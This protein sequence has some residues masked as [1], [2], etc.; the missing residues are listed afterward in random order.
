M[1]SRQHFPIMIVGA[2]PGDPDLL[3][4]KAMRL[5]GE[6]DVIVYDRLVSETILDLIPAGTMQIFAGKRA[7]N[8]F[9]P[10]DE[11]NALLV[12]LY[13]SGR[14]VMRLKGGDPFVFGRG[15]EEV[16]HLAERGIRFEIVPGITSSAGAA[17]YAGIP[18]THRGLAHGVH[19]VTGHTTAADRL[20]LNWQS[21][22]DPDTTL[23]IYMGLTNIRKIA[24]ELI[25]AGLPAKTPAAAINMGTRPEQR[26]ITA[27]LDTL[28]HAIER[29]ELVGATLLVVGQVV[30]LAKT[31]SWFTPSQEA[32]IKAGEK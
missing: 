29:A 19:F 24:S 28:A 18:L 23:V 6:V 15:G 5:I 4:V 25:T 27:T 13:Y 32:E 9:M 26:T 21:L 16:V 11:I 1:I 2:G 14:R 12:D 17:A 31:L 30:K 22:A 20:N 8:H 7:Q 3:T 10:Q